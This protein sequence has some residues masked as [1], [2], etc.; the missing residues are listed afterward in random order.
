M[1]KAI[2]WIMRQ[3]QEQFESQ[4]KAA[5]FAHKQCLE[6]AKKLQGIDVDF[7]QREAVGYL[8]TIRIVKTK[9]AEI[10]EILKGFD[11][12]KSVEKAPGSG[13]IVS[14]AKSK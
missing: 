13:K 10:T 14:R 9:L 7:K 4:L 2:A 11:E 8:E 6:A 3:Y 5:E 1:E 12:E